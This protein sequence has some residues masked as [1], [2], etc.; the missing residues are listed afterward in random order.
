[1]CTIWA[2][3]VSEVI[4]MLIDYESMDTFIP[5]TT[6]E[7]MITDGR[8]NAYRITPDYGYVLHDRELDTPEVDEFGVPTGGT[9]LGYYPMRRTCAAGY[10]FDQE[11]IVDGHTAYG[12]REFFAVKAVD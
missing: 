11:R 4:I 3:I 10:D 12:A 6:M 5:N 1:M 8:L 7:K 9:V 2:G